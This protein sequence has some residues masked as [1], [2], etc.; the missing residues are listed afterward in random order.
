MNLKIAT[1]LYFLNMFGSH[2]ESGN[3]D[4]VENLLK[5]DARIIQDAIN[6]S[7]IVR[8]RRD[9]I[10]QKQRVRDCEREKMQR[11]GRPPGKISEHP[12]SLNE[13]FS[14]V[15]RDTESCG[16]Q[17]DSNANTPKEIHSHINFAVEK[18]VVPGKQL[19]NPEDDGDG[20]EEVVTCEN[21]PQP[22]IVTVS[23]SHRMSTTEVDLLIQKYQQEEAY[24]VRTWWQMF[25]TKITVST[26]ENLHI[27][28]APYK[29]FLQFLNPCHRKIVD[30]ID[31]MLTKAEN[32][33][34]QNTVE[35]I[36]IICKT[37][38]STAFQSGVLKLLFLDLF[39]FS[40]SLHDITPTAVTI[41]SEIDWNVHQTENYAMERGKWFGL[42]L[43]NHEVVRF[44]AIAN[45]VMCN[46]YDYQLRTCYEITIPV[47]NSS[48]G[49]NSHQVS[50][51]LLT[52]PKFIKY[53]NT[54]FRYILGRL[55][56][57]LRK[58]KRYYAYVSF[59]RYVVF[60]IAASYGTLYAIFVTAFFRLKKR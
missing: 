13:K 54:K 47:P 5:N 48:T 25:C 43:Y 34:D 4:E 59:L 57:N 52:D 6:R 1:L 38:S 18:I 21:P 49:N 10:E 29:Y 51:E 31:D 60:G 23:S 3:I 35:D 36:S 15:D 53:L 24:L 40:D 20:D 22:T 44:V 37:L 8:S 39:E 12:R 32:Y 17:T 50:K 55:Q 42:R 58:E 46:A 7:N 2:L 56:E 28:D 41:Q 16:T 26:A 14:S 19:Q 30:S 27:K 11:I 45:K 33:C 9:E